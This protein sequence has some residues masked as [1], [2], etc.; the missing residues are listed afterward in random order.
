MARQTPALVPGLIRFPAMAMP[1]VLRAD[2]PRPYV[3]TKDG[4]LYTEKNFTKVKFV[5]DDTDPEAP[6]LK[7]EKK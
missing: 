7:A 2:E 6:V 3:N 1:A 4:S 5:V